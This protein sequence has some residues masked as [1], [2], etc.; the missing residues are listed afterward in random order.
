MAPLRREWEA[1]KTECTVMREA[2]AGESEKKRAAV[3]RRIG[4]KLRAFADRIAGVRVLDAACGSGNFLYVALLL[5]DLQNEV[6]SF[7]DQMGAGRFFISVSP[8][9]LYGIEVNEYAHEL[10]QVTIWIGYIQW[11]VSNGY[12][13]PSEPILKRM[14]NIQQMD[15]ILAFDAEG[16]P[17]EPDWPEVDVIIGNPPFLGSIK[18]RE[19]LGE[20][21]LENLKTLYRDRI[22][23]KSD[24]V[25][26]WFEKAR[27]EVQNKPPKR[28]GLIA[29][30]AI[31]KGLSRTVIDRIKSSGDMFM[32]YSNRPWILEGASVRVSIICFDNGDEKLK[33]LDE[34]LVEFINTDL[35]SSSDLTTSNVLPENFHIAFPGTKKYGAFDIEN[36]I[37]L[38]MLSEK[39][40]PNGKPNS[41]VVKPWVN[42]SDL[43]GIHRRMWIIDF[44]TDTPIDFASQY[45]KPFEYVRE[46]V[47][48]GRDKER[49]AK[50]RDKWWLFERPRP[51]MRHAIKNLPRFIATPVVSKYRIFVYL[52]QPTIPDAKVTVFARGDDY[53]F[54]VLH[55]QIHALWSDKKGARHGVGNDLTYNIVECFGTFPFPWPP[56][57]EPKDDP[58]VVAIAAAA[59][60][61]VEKRDRWLNPEGL[62]EIERKKRTLTNLYNQRPTWLDLAHRK[63]DAAVFDAYGWPSDLSDEEILEKLLKLNLERAG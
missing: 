37:A 61:L 51:E 58:R 32:A 34:R 3:S 7:S 11:L 57:K 59:K 35:S 17:V 36:S 42:G 47:K 2:S 46:I 28:C 30:Q 6:I 5:L 15:A 48:P 33:Y 12:G 24:L 43:V 1:L 41:D 13:L 23:P 4:E 54:G 39:N 22:P 38:K 44:G 10:A 62:S 9:Q 56:G 19:E 14:D 60:E 50:T 21:Y 53:F 18:M 55:S 45:Q 31:R 63:L 40:N 27:F 16:K 20:E 29:T 25:C 8:T 26:Y 52:L 49:I